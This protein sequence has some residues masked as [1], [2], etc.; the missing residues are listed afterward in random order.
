ME[1][2]LPVPVIK[3]AREDQINIFRV[4]I[5]TDEGCALPIAIL[6]AICPSAMLTIIREMKSPVKLQINSF[7]WL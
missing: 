7:S 5:F 6:F 4:V 1:F 3:Q 2:N